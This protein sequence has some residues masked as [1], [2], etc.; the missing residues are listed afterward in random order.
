MRYEGWK[1]FW[2]WEIVK[3]YYFFVGVDDIV[4]VYV[5]FVDFWVVVVIL[6]FFDVSFFFKI[7]GFYVFV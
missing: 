1:F 3:G 4:F 6:E 7:Y 5:F 2:G